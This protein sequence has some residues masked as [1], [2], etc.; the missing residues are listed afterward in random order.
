MYLFPFLYGFH[1]QKAAKYSHSTIFS[2]PL[3]VSITKFRLLMC[4]KVLPCVTA[5]PPFRKP[6]I[7]KHTLQG[8]GA[9]SIKLKRAPTSD[10]VRHM[11]PTRKGIMCV[12]CTPQGKGSCASYAPHKERDHVHHMHP[13]RKGI[14]CVMRLARKQIMCVVHPTRKQIMCVVHPTR[15]QIMCV[16]HPTRKQIMCVVHPTRKQIMCVVHPTR[17]QIMCVVHPTRKHMLQGDCALSIRLKRAPTR[18]RIMCVVNPTR[19][20]IMCVRCTPQGKGS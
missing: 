4:T 11:H 14:M 1:T 12:I 9:L 3:P 13:T 6:S 17:K 8:D 5:R 19:K 20:Q 18:K 16:V 2:L 7:T 10:H 15:K